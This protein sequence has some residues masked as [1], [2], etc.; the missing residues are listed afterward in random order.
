MLDHESQSRDRCPTCGRTRRVGKGRQVRRFENLY[1]SISRMAIGDRFEVKTEED[2]QK[3]R[4]YAP[5]LGCR[6]TAYRVDTGS[7]FIYV[8]RRIA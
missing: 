7:G 3:C 5:R 1:I 2:A 8:V 6:I 4:V